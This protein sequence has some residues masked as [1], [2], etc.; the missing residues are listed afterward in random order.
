M[1]VTLRYAPSDPGVSLFVVFETLEEAVAQA[2]HDVQVLGREVQDIVDG[3]HDSE[4]EDK[5][6]VLM[7]AAQLGKQV[8]GEKPNQYSGEERILPVEDK[9]RTELTSL[10][11]KL[12]EGSDPDERRYIQTLLAQGGL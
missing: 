6:T 5:P 12:I 8:A 2:Q 4:S 9:R 10:V 7:S 1:P 3:D 11:E